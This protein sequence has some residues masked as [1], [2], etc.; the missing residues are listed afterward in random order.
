MLSHDNLVNGTRIVLV[1][2]GGVLKSRM[3]QRVER[4]AR[5]KSV[6]DTKTAHNKY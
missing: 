4:N 6:H 2:G 3:V 1:H 5:G